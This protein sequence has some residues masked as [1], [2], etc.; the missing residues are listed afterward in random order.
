M[1]FLS[2][3]IMTGRV[4]DVDAR[5]H[6]LAHLF[7]GLS[8]FNKQFLFQLI[9]L[10]HTQPLGSPVFYQQDILLQHWSSGMEYQ[11]LHLTHLLFY[12]RYEGVVFFLIVQY[13]HIFIIYIIHYFFDMKVACPNTITTSLDLYFYIFCQDCGPLWWRTADYPGSVAWGPEGFLAVDPIAR[14]LLIH[15][16][17]INF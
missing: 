2:R 15:N 7:Q 14:F 9:P 16:Y 11:A 8:C 12:M 10:T 5:L 1:F 17:I 13:F 6:F 3:A 4:K